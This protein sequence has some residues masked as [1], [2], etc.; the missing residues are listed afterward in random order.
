M[1]QAG[2]LI[3]NVTFYGAGMCIYCV[4]RKNMIQV[5]GDSPAAKLSISR[6]TVTMNGVQALNSNLKIMNW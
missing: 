6:R 3:K 1:L 4:F 2:I 5:R